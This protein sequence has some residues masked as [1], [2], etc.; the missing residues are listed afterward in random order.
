[1]SIAALLTIAKTGN[2]LNVHGHMNGLFY[3]LFRATPT[4]YRSSQARGQIGA[5]AA[6]LCHSNRG[7]PDPVSKARD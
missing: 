1:M 7:T 4:A 2:N 5:T 6:S 3:L